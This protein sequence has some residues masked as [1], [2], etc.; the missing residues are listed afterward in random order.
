LDDAI[1]REV[2]GHLRTP[3]KDKPVDYTD[4]I[5]A[6]ETV[7][8]ELRSAYAK[9][10]I[11][12]GDFLPMLNEANKVLSDLQ[13]KAAV[14]TKATAAGR[15]PYFKNYKGLVQ[16][17]LSQQRAVI[18]TH[19]KAIVIDPATKHGQRSPDF[20][21]VTVAWAAGYEENLGDTYDTQAA[22]DD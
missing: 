19:I 20:H 5:R 13:A 11:T 15:F 14:V 8:A 12:M 21:R 1:I 7:V 4:Q 16:A 6:Q 9:G 22:W 17:D 3:A 2:A 10:Q 18:G